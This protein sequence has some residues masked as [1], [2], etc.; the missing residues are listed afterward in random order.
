MQARRA[1]RVI[2]GP[3]CRPPPTPLFGYISPAPPTLLWMH[4]PTVYI[5]PAPG[6][7]LAADVAL[8]AIEVRL[9]AKE[10]PGPA[11]RPMS[12]GQQL[13]SVWLG[14]RALTAVP[15]P[16][17]SQNETCAIPLVHMLYIRACL[18]APSATPP[19]PKRHL[20]AMSH[21][22][23]SMQWPSSPAHSGQIRDFYGHTVGTLCQARSPAV[24]EIWTPAVVPTLVSIC[25]RSISIRQGQSRPNHG[26]MSTQAEIP[27]SSKS[28]SP[29]P[30]PPHQICMNMKCLA[31]L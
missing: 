2:P 4:T 23:G 6:S 16:P 27:P 15:P 10:P 9:V 8:S 26:A 24:L 5:Q 14:S 12:V 17:N 22:I 19:P 13:T 31:P 29:L 25:C 3:A 18:A 11:F 20:F 30:S 21:T 7:R 1:S 28:N